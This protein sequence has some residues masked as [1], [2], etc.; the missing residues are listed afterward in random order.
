MLYHLGD[1]GEDNSNSMTLRYAQKVKMN[2]INY[3]YFLT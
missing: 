3:L 1:K 2:N